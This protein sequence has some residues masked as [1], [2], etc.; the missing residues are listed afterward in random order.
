MRDDDW[1]AERL[2][3]IWQLLFPDLERKNN[4]V[5]RFKGRWKNK[6]GHIKRMKN[7][8]TEIV[9]N[10]LFK[11]EKVPEYI[12][13]TTIAHELVHYSHGFHS[14]FPQKY[15]YPHSGGVVNRELRKRG[16]GH[17]MG[18]ERDFVKR[19]WPRIFKELCPDK[20]QRRRRVKFSF[21]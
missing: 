3:Q 10:G 2:S 14:P 11:S 9:I 20:L 19:Q 16:F 6:F 4:V 12:V 21:F 5:V 15:K 8:D 7:K 18:R 17:M 1:L 13:D